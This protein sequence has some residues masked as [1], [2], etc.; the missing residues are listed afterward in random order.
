MP[1]LGAIYRSETT[2]AAASL[3]EFEARWGLAIRRSCQLGGAPGTRL[4]DVPLPAGDPEDDPKPQMPWRLCTG[5]GVCIADC[6]R[7][8]S[9]HPHEGCGR[10]FTLSRRRDLF[11]PRCT[12]SNSSPYRS[13]A[14]A[15]ALPVALARKASAWPVNASARRPASRPGRRQRLRGSARCSPAGCD[16]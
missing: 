6:G 15:P 7:H 11:A 16:R 5:Q 14:T 12:R 1:V 10:E 4:A 13:L 2:E 3:D 8:W 9:V